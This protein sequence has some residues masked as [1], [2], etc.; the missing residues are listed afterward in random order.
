V[1]ALNNVNTVWQRDR[2]IAYLLLRATLGLNIFIHGA[3]RI[4]LGL[5]IFAGSLVP[6]FQKTFLPAW[7]VYT[8]G[9][10]LPWA[11]ALIGLLLFAGLRT[12]AALIGGSLMML[13]LTFGTALRQDWQT[14]YLQL[15]YAVVY[16]AL[17]ASR[18]HNLYSVDAVMER[19]K[20]GN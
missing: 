20:T 2:A 7:S 19:N 9:L 17:L 3:S 8:F 6:L 16:A 11:E 13:I 12:R 4:V 5:H 10:T 14:A 15:M 18:Q 1:N